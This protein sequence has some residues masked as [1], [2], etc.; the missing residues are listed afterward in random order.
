MCI[1]DRYRDVL[2]FAKENGQEVKRLTPNWIRLT[3]PEMSV[4]DKVYVGLKWKFVAIKR[5][6]LASK[7]LIKGVK[8]WWA[9]RQRCKQC[10]KFLL[11]EAQRVKSRG[12]VEPPTMDEV[13]SFIAEM[14]GNLDAHCVDRMPPSKRRNIDRDI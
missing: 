4:I 13:Q 7:S 1:R 12:P 6:V 10:N 5:H 14:G 3:S 8:K 11:A 2:Q 9:I